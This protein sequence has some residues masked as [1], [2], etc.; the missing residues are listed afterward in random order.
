L[1][2]AVVILYKTN[3]PIYVNFCNPLN[4]I[5]LIRWHNC[6][7]CLGNRD[8]TRYAFFEGQIMVT[9]PIATGGAILAV[10]TLAIALVIAPAHAG[11]TLFTGADDGAGSLAAA[12]NSVT[13]AT[14]FDVAVAGLG[15]AKIITFE[16]SPLGTFSSLALGSGVS[17]TG[18]NV[19]TNN[20]SIVDTTSNIN[21]TPPCS[22]ASCGYNTTSGGSHFL[23]LFG[24]TATFTFS[25][26]TEAFGAY[27][28]GVQN[29]GETIFFSDGT[30]QTLDIPNPGF[31]GG[32]TFVGFTDPSKSIA[33]ITINVNNDIVGVDDVRYVTDPVPEPA[34]LALL[35]GALAGLAIARRRKHLSTL[36]PIRI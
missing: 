8:L 10:A 24:G 25:D 22:N 31:A 32:T 26:G 17:L 29:G 28:S 20:Q 3:K 23:S 33:S 5:I 35:G 15:P 36:K 19:N 13:A 7:W 21:I 16:S 34:T 4:N 9:T 14:G 27:L 18:A 11:L 2:I 1:L 6:C 30:I 12:P